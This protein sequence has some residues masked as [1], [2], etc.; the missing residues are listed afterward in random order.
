MSRSEGLRAAYV[1]EHESG[2]RTAERLMDVPAV[3]LIAEQC[4]K[5]HER[6]GGMGGRDGGHR[7]VCGKHG[8][9]GIIARRGPCDG[10]GQEVQ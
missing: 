5:M 2:L 10:S 8:H 1:E 6:I 3:C 7:I 4:L 9:I